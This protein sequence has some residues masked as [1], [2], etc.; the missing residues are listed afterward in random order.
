VRCG[1]CS[2]RYVRAVAS[3][4]AAERSVPPVLG[5]RRFG[6]RQGIGREREWLGS[7]ASSVE[8]ARFGRKGEQ[9]IR[10]INAD[11]AY[12]RG[13]VGSILVAVLISTS[14][15]GVSGAAPSDDVDPQVIRD[16]N[17]TM[18]ATIVVDAGKANAEAF[19]WFGFVQAAVYNAVV[20]IT[21]DYELY[22]WDRR[23]SRKASP[24]AAA[25]AAA[26]DVLLNYFPGS[27]ARLDA[28]LVSSLAGVTDGSAERQGVKYGQAAAAHL[29]EL[30]SPER[31]DHLRPGARR[32]R[33]AADATGIR[34]VLRPVA[35]SGQAADDDVVHAV[36]SGTTP[37]VDIRAVH[38]G[39]QRSQGTRGEGQPDADGA[40]D[41]DGDVHDRRRDRAVS[42]RP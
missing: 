35:R 34:A 25:A 3:S 18:V 4:L 6:C 38:G 17:A 8:D 14:F 12:G 11:R 20:G 21:R 2:I 19:M 24:E 36:P 13:I 37:G 42:G 41:P 5:R 30:R 32:G 33:V 29:I 7:W 23:G 31:A 26:H 16:W 27:Q 15:S 1:R 9:M 40:A 28:Q 10:R 22:Q 39:L